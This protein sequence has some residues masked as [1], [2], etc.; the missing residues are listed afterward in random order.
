MMWMS[1]SCSPAAAEL[2]VVTDSLAFAVWFAPSAFASSFLR[3]SFWM[4]SGVVELENA[5]RLLSGDQTGPAALFGR[6]VITRASPPANDRIAICAGR[7]LP[8]SSFSPPRTNAMS[9]P[10]GDQRGCSS[11]LPLVRRMGASLLEVATI[12]MDV[13]YP[14]RFS[15]VTTRVKTARD[16]SGETCGSAIQTKLNRSFSVIA[17]AA[18]GWG[19][20]SWA[21]RGVTNASTIIEAATTAGNGNFMSI[22]R[23]ATAHTQRLCIVLCRAAGGQTT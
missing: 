22:L 15:S 3:C 17:R 19:V 2:P 1:D 12:Q 21:A 23:T 18:P 13:S 6:S 11:C 4:S 9:L 7:G 8:V 14:V 20:E 5:M 10:S 16:P